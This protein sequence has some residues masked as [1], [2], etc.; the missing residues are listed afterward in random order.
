[1]VSKRALTL[2][3]AVAAVAMGLPSAASADKPPKGPAAEELASFAAP[4]CE[5]GCGSGSTIGP[6][7][8]LYVTDGPGGRVLRVDP[9]TGEL[10]TFASG[11]PPAVPDVGIGG[12]MDIAF[13]GRTAYVLVTVVGPALGQPDVVNGIYRIGRHGSATPIADIGTWSID[14]PPETDFFVPSGVQYAMQQF[15]AGFLVT[16]GHHNRV[17]RVTL[18]GHI[19]EVI[20]FGN[21][22]PT[23]LDVD[24]WTIYMGQAGPIPHDPEDGKVV[25]FTPW[26]AATDVAAGASL[27]VDVEFGRGHRLYALSQGF[28]DLAADRGQRGRAGL[29]EHRRAPAGR[30]ERQLRVHRRRSGPAD[31]ARVHR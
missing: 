2:L 27:I 1:M 25:R 14:N 28:W 8:A 11:L 31:V 19:S 10:T 17:L 20:A 6:D 23:G 13:V 21:I 12:A 5:G 9:K 16:D 24:G 4:G 7:R 30:E 3:M 15:G 22:V 18:G 29:A 26:S